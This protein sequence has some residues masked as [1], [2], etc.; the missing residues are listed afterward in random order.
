[1]PPF[2]SSLA[3]RTLRTL[4]QRPSLTAIPAVSRPTLSRFQ[5][6]LRTPTA[7]TAARAAGAGPITRHFSTSPFRQATYNQVRRGCRVSQRARRSR[8][9]ALIGRAQMKGVCLKTGI[10]KPK[11]P[12][13]G[14][15]KT[16]R[17]RLSSGKVVTAYI[18]GEG[19]NVQQHSVVLVRG[20]RAQ[21]CPGVKY[22]LV[23]GAMDLGGVA[24]RLTS[25]SK[26]GTKKPKKD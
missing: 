3:L 23:R 6:V 7:I 10:T 19:H 26:Y 8:S 17:V 15:R 16:A 9:P 20:G 21:D 12:N 24:S 5:P 25:R 18:P 11:K 1:M 14:E 22:H 13:S 4:V 2:I